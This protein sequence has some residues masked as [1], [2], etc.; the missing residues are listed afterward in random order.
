MWISHYRNITTSSSSCKRRNRGTG[1]GTGMQEEEQ[2]WEAMLGTPPTLRFTCYR[3]MRTI[4]GTHL[5]L[6][7]FLPRYPTNRTKVMFIMSFVEAMS[8]VCVLLNPNL[9]W[10]KISAWL[11]LSLLVLIAK[12]GYLSFST[13][14]LFCSISF[15]KGLNPT[16]QQ[17][18]M[19]SDHFY[20][21]HCHHATVFT[22]CIRSMMGRYCFHR[23]VS[24]HIW[25]VPHLL[26]IILPLV[27]CPFWGVAHF[28]PIIL[29]LVPCLFC[30]VPPSWDGVPPARSRWGYPRT[31]YG[32]HPPAR[33][34]KGVPAMRQAVCLLCS[35]IRIFL[36]FIYQN[37]RYISFSRANL[38]PQ[39][40]NK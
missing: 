11:T 7:S 28:H 12:Y 35:R 3:M 14:N 26:P 38:R 15:P 24:V 30:M 19:Q 27:P 33:T 31:W 32:Y 36:F 21:H 13:C 17:H 8:P 29:P 39:K 4:H 9:R 23:C 25:G 34:T 16:R 18:F 2:G 37:N 6:F 20:F 22:A 10:E 5:G 1:G 40:Q